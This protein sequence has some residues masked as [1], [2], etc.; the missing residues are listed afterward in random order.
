MSHPPCVCC[1]DGEMFIDH[2]AAFIWYLC[3]AL[4]NTVRGGDPMFS[5]VVAAVRVPRNA[6]VA[7]SLLR[8]AVRK[9]TRAPMCTLWLR[10]GICRRKV[11]VETNDRLFS[12]ATDSPISKEN[13]EKAIGALEGLGGVD[14]G[15]LQLDEEE[16]EEEDWD[17]YVDMLNEETGE[18]GGPR[19]PEPTRYGDW[20]QK[21]RA[22]D[23]E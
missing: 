10:G 11:G 22:S 21:G 1:S 13:V 8:Q 23:F 19:G 14:D 16:E 20:Q 2:T 4:V 15:D 3:V 6:G 9:Y 18:W 12:S 5:H 7:P 17:G